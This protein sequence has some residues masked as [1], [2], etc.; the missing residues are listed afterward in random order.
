MIL[1]PLALAL[2]FKSVAHSGSVIDSTRDSVM[3]EVRRC[4]DNT[5]VPIYRDPK[6]MFQLPNPMVADHFGH[7]EFFTE[8]P[9]VRIRLVRDLGETSVDTCPAKERK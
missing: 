6:L 5:F 4:E 8:T 3:V 9:Y 1:A 2:A 7:Y